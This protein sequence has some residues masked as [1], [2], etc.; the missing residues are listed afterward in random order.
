MLIFLGFP[1]G[2]Q[3]LLRE[4]AKRLDI[5]D[6][7][8]F[9]DELDRASSDLGLALEQHG[10]KSFPEVVFLNFDIS[11]AINTL[12]KIKSNSATRTLPV[13]GLGYFVKA[14]IVDPFYYSGGNSYV[15]KP[16]NFEEMMQIASEVLSY[17]QRMTQLPGPLM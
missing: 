7:C 11:E 3:R 4:A 1:D 5:L 16:D 6:T 12:K 15:R 13:V 17:W 14:E 9:L 10:R 2:E 8:I